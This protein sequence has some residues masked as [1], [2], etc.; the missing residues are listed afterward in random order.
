MM[1]CAV[2]LSNRFG[3]SSFSEDAFFAGDMPDYAAV[4]VIRPFWKSKSRYAGLCGEIH[5]SRAILVEQLIYKSRHFFLSGISLCNI[6]SDSITINVK[7]ITSFCTLWQF[8]FF[9]VHR[10]PI[11]ALADGELTFKS[12]DTGFH[13]SFL[14]K[15]DYGLQIAHAVYF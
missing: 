1:T 4:S 9:D 6:N 14:G 5:T 13:K 12:V 7:D 8:G 11:C 15:M 2:D 3:R 10:C